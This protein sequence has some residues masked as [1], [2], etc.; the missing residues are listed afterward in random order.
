MGSPARQPRRWR[1]FWLSCGLALATCVLFGSAA[2]AAH[3]ACPA[4]S[5]GAYPAAVLADSPVAYYRLDEA[6]GP[7][8]CDS[9][10]TAVDGTYNAAGLIFGVP[11]ALLGDPD[12]AVRADGTNGVIGIG[13]ASPITGNQSFT[14]EGWYRSTGTE[15]NQSLV[16]I[17]TTAGAGQ[18]AGLTI[19]SSNCGGPTSNIALDTFASANCWDTSTRGVNLF[20]G[21]WHHA[22][23]AYDAG[24]G[25]VTAYVDGLSLGAETPVAMN[26]AASSIR[27]GNWSDAI[28]NQPYRGEADEVAVYAKALPA[29]RIS[30]HFQRARADSD[31][32]GVANA[33]DNCP[34]NPNASQL[35]TNGDR[36]GDACDPDD[37][38]DGVA[39]AAD[40]CPTES[41]AQ[42]NG[43]PAASLPPPVLGKRVNAATVSGDVFVS[44]PAGAARAAKSV[45][46]LKG[47]V[48]VP[49]R[50]ARQLPV[51]SI[52]D[53]RS[54]KV[55]LTS[56][57]TGGRKTFSG[58]FSAGVFQVLQSGK[59]AAKG[60]TELRL[61]GASFK[62]CGSA[63]R[64]A[65]S[66]ARSK[67]VVR[68]LRSK[69]T[70]RF[71]TRGR[72]SS[73]TVRGT[74]WLTVDRCD[75]TLTKVTRGAVTVRDIL[76]RKTVLLRRGKSYL[77]GARR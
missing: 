51:G 50:E 53:T 17:G 20:D 63:R 28:T 39:D 23:V 4:A 66:A 22:A 46:G 55:R 72:Y 58:D 3:A 76:R 36:Q 16:A 12:T 44:L 13:G 65:V 1:P 8:M 62:A 9:S 25:T 5:A 21:G 29:A 41:G 7:A 6:T 19:W 60:L 30:A 15:Q 40:L 74:E 69:A 47:R 32:D 67:R 56:A 42:A 34:S 70:G 11:G 77:A 38:G 48:F 18:I 64:S 37:D 61:K 75:G 49:L 52:L 10:P 2:P 33:S 26:L 35:D 57:A 59:R 43:C 24:A 45:P 71:R 31:G 54:G 73:A 68:R 14:L 27:V